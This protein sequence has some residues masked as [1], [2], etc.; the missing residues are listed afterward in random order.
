L[1][2]EPESASVDVEKPQISAAERLLTDEQAQGI[3]EYVIVVGAIVFAAIVTF[4]ALG[5][6]LL[7]YVS[8]MRS[9]LNNVPTS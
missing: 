3:T 7:G 5:T 8:G 6:Q 4:V 2:V 9:E 1:R